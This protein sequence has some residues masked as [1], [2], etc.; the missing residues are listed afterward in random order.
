MR[1]TA[2]RITNSILLFIVTACWVVQLGRNMKSLQAVVGTHAVSSSRL[3]SSI[4]E[5]MIEFIPDQTTTYA[6]ITNF[7]AKYHFVTA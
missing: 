6:Y 4:R 5:M 1:A 7:L 3:L 2:P